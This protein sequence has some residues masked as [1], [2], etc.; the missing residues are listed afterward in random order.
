[1]AGQ[2]LGNQTEVVCMGAEVGTVIPEPIYGGGKVGPV[3]PEPTFLF[4]GG[5]R[6]GVSPCSGGAEFGEESL[7]SARC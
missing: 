4:L 3:I 6:E 2:D 5:F 7:E 1:V